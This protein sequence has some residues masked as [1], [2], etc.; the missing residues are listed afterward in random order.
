MELVSTLERTKTYNMI[1][2]NTFI[3]S[4]S[5]KLY[6]FCLKITYAKEDAED[7]F[8]DTWFS[9]LQKQ[10]KLQAAENPQKFLYTTALSLWKSKQRKYARRKRIAPELSLDAG[11]DILLIEKEQGVEDALI[12]KAEQEFIHGLVDKLHEKHRIPLILYYTVGMDISE[13]AEI[14]DLPPGTV[15][16]RLYTARQEIKKG[17]K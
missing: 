16:S 10:E 6:R 7:L 2:V 4:Y 11:A 5:T 13:I 14:L 1:D 15:K 8:Q 9:I 17:M 12:Q 3:D